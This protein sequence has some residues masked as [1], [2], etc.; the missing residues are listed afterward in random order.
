MMMMIPEG[1]LECVS[2]AR[3]DVR[4]CVHMCTLCIRVCVCVCV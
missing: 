1:C 4:L 2:G 3:M